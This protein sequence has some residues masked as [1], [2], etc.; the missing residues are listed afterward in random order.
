[1]KD[2]PRVPLLRSPRPSHAWTLNAQRTEGLA[3]KK[4]HGPITHDE[5]N[6]HH[7][8]HLRVPGR[9]TGYHTGLDTEEGVIAPH[10]FMKADV[11]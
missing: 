11:S 10:Y 9:I 4:P 1:M 8:P 2:A 5:I 6:H 7:T 3:Y